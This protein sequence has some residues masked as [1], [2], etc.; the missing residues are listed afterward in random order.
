MAYEAHLDR[1]LHARQ[2]SE[3]VTAFSI[4]HCTLLQQGEIDAG[5]N[6]GLSVDSIGHLSAQ[7]SGACQR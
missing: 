4:S 3:L 7:H 1:R 2:T 6:D 5:T